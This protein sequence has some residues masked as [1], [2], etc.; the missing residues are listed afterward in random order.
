[1]G[2]VLAAMEEQVLAAAVC[3]I[4]GARPASAASAHEAEEPFRKVGGSF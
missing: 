2:F 4:R 3:A 1:V